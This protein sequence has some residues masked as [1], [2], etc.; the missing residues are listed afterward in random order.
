M[1][2]YSEQK[3]VKVTV[4]IGQGSNFKLVFVIHK[5]MFFMCV[6]FNVVVSVY[7]SLM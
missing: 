5:L 3:R 1:V 7:S 6:V 4:M 2:T